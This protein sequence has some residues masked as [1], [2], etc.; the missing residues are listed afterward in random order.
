MRSRRTLAPGRWLAACLGTL[1]L[2]FGGAASAGIADTKHNLGSGPG[3]AGRNS[4]GDTAEICVFCHTPHGGDV[5]APAPLWNKRLGT[6]GA[7]PGGGSYTTYDTL[8]TPSLDGTVAAVGSI[9]MACLSCH[10]GTQAMDN[11]INAPGSGGLVADGGGNDGR[12]FTW[13]GANVNTLGRLSGGAALIGTDLSNDHPIGIQYCGGGLTGTGTTVTGTC[14]DGDFRAPQTQVI[15]SNQ[16]FWVDTGGAGKQRTDLPLY[17][18]A[19]G[20]LDDTI[21]HFDPVAS[22]GTGFKFEKYDGRDLLAC[23]REAVRVFSDREAWR[24]LMANGMAKDFSWT[25]SAAEY[26]RLY[27]LARKSRA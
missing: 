9:S 1:L 19:T 2:L 26:S 3:L 25:A 10:D 11:I 17:V 5:N 22:T 27:E 7:P 23:V 14:R 12:A 16:V 8:Q 20:G 6:A 15:N 24:R 18:R 4:T 13:T 21:Q